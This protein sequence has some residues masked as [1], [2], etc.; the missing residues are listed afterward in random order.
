MADVYLEPDHETA[1]VRRGKIVEMQTAL[2][3]AHGAAV[4]W[5]AVPSSL[6]YGQVPPGGTTSE[7]REQ[8]TGANRPFLMS[9]S[10]GAADL[11][12]EELIA[13]VR[14]IRT[15]PDVV[16]RTDGVA[17]SGRPRL[18]ADWQVDNMN[19][20]ADKVEVWLTD[21]QSYQVASLVVQQR[22][23]EWVVVSSSYAGRRGR[24]GVVR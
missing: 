10:P 4:A 22:G 17:A 8:R 13:L 21:P 3:P 15:S 23:A 2:T 11:T 6:R 5:E 16:P 1:S 9:T 20:A 12:D 7:N 24:D 19:K 14:L 18:A